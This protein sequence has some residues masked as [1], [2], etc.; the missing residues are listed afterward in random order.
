MNR[1]ETPQYMYLEITASVLENILIVQKDHNPLAVLQYPKG[2]NI[3]NGNI[4]NITLK[5]TKLRFF[6]I[7]LGG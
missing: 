4:N 7:F 1:F 2:S 5:L 6:G 3:K